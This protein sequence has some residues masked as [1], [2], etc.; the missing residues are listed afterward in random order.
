MD[1]RKYFCLY[2]FALALLLFFPGLGARDF[3]APVEPRYAEIARVMFN[4]GEWIVPTVN[5]DLYTDKPILYF[6]IVLI[7]AKIFGGV[8]EWTVRLPAA[9]GGAGFVV[10]T[11]LMGRDFFGARVGFYGAIILA[12]SVRVIWE[13][14]WA[15]IDMLFCFFFA[16]T[17]YFGARTLLRKGNPYEILFAY[18][19]MALA[20]LAKGLIG[21]VL[22]GLLFVAF[23]LSERDWRLIAAAKLPLGIPIFLLVAAPWFYLIHQATDGKWLSDFIY[24]HHVRRYTVRAGHRQPFYYYFMT[25]PP[26]FLPWTIFLAPA[27]LAYRSYRRAWA[28]PVSRSFFLWFLVV[29]LFF[30]LSSSKRELY[31]LPLLPPLALFVGNY[32][33]ALA[34][35]KLPQDALLRWVAMGCFAITGLSGVALPIATWWVRPD[36]FQAILV[37]SMVL[38][39]GGICAVFFVWRRRPLKVLACITAMMVGTVLTASYGILPYLDEFKSDR[40]FSQTIKRLVPSSAPLYVYADT[41]NDFNY[42]SDREVIPV[43]KSPLQLEKLRGRSETG[44]LL[45]KNSDLEKISMIPAE[46]IVAS[47]SSGSKTWYLVEFNKPATNKRAELR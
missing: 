12:T 28:D 43:V 1:T 38:A 31:L 33:D 46:W 2:L 26:D 42:Y 37:T 45:I 11:Y 39:A 20:T 8:S 6:W 7:A 27:L 19:F 21:V 3:W 10:T 13:S 22:P 18:A 44:Y 14:R 17:I 29:F 32:L 16:L 25:L 47:D 30:E 23:A 5:G 24:I 34:T 4:K 36:A 40:P 35:N 41:M 9:L 15:H